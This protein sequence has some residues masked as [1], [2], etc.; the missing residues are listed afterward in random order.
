[1][2]TSRSQMGSN[3]KL[4]LELHRGD[5]TKRV[6]EAG[7]IEDGRCIALIVRIVLVL[8][9]RT[10]HAGLAGVGGGHN[11]SVEEW[12]N[13]GANVARRGQRFVFCDV[14]RFNAN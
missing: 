7:K 14:G 13:V 9:C 5:W 3:D 10:L 4:N 12:R 6:W 11:P 2:T 1:V 8:E